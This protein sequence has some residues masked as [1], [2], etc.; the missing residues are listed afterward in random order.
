[1][2]PERSGAT[3]PV[4][5]AEFRST[6]STAGGPDKTILFSAGA[7]DP[8][9][10]RIVPIFLVPSGDAAPGLA[11]LARASGVAPIVLPDG[12][13]A[14]LSILPRVE[15]I[16]REHGCRVLHAHDFKTDVLGLLL[17][18]RD[19]RLGLLATAH[20]WSRPLGERQ[21]LYHGADRWA[22]RRYPRVVAVSEATARELRRIRVRPERISIIPNGIDVEA[23]RPLSADRRLPAGVRPGRRIVG[24]VGRLSIDKDMDT[25]I[26]AVAQMVRTRLDVDLVM[27]GNGPEAPRLRALAREAGVEDRV[28]F[29]GH[30]SD[31]R[32][33]YAA[34]D[35]F[36]LSSRTEGMPNA[37]LEAMALQRP[38]VVTPVGGVA[39]LA[40]PA[41]AIHVA[42][43]DVEAMAAAIETLLADPA[44][45][46]VV[47]QF[48]FKHRLRR[49][50]D[51]YEELVPP[52][53]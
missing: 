26:L 38:C 13:P 36:V 47:D 10:V 22:L 7:H 31:L 42:T 43:G 41:E 30:R 18:R 17:G 21:R 53:R 2:K 6:H 16:M 34:M 23:W 5:V 40:G 14:D 3:S 48:S 20:G 25:L 44:R 32:E 45:A 29:L 35:V 39:E 8:A 9:R 12:G 27:V 51:L 4:V 52:P 46:G 37:L 33:L 24:T 49:M 15:R 19:R 11:D 1:M 28:F 50:E